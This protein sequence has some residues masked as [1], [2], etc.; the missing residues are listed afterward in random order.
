MEPI[1]R[2]T[3]RVLPVSP[4]GAV[5]LLQDQDPARPGILRWGSI[6]GATDPGETLVEAAIRE[7]FEET[8][9]VVEAADLTEPFLRSSHDFTWDGGDY[10]SDS[11]FFALPLDRDVEVSFDH[12]EPAEVGHVFKAAWW[13]PADLAADGTAV[14]DQMPAIMEAAVRTVLGDAP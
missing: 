5:L 6:G 12:L 9:L 7:T 1:L 13:T 11:T 14:S 10:R 8:G 3:A 2:I 4:D